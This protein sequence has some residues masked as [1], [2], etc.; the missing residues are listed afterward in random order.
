LDGPPPLPSD[1]PPSLPCG[2]PPEVDINS[3]ISSQNPVTGGS[4]REEQLRR[5]CEFLGIDASMSQEYS[6]VTSSRGITRYQGSFQIDSSLES[7]LTTN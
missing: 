5:K 1:Q 4:F 3:Q 6:M 7:A 2:P